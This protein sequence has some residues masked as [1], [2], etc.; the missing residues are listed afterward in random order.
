[1]DL[2]FGYGP[3]RFCLFSLPGS[4]PNLGGPVVGMVVLSERVAVA[5]GF[6][7]DHAALAVLCVVMIHERIAVVATIQSA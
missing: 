5:A 4:L 6:H 2:G 7:A 1:M 3:S